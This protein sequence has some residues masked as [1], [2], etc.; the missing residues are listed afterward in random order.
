MEDA[1]LELLRRLTLSD[2]LVLRRLMCERTVGLSTLDD[3]T[4]ALVRLASLVAM[5]SSTA[6]FHGA[7]DAA[8]AAGADPAEIVETLILVAPVVGLCRVSTAARTLSADLG[9]Q[10]NAQTAY[11]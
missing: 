8:L 9:Y 11:P 3:R 4:S 1:Q 6:S 5:G 2:E 7:I 10:T